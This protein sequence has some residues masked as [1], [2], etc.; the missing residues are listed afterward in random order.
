MALELTPP[1]PGSL[2]P[3]RRL[4]ELVMRLGMRYRHCPGRPRNYR[5]D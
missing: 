5:P 3:C 2:N 1:E 4:R